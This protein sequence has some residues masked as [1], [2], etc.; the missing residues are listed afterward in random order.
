MLTNGLP[1][2][3]ATFGAAFAD[4]FLAASLLTVGLS[5]GTNSNELSESICLGS[6]LLALFF[7]DLTAALTVADFIS[8]AE[9]LS[10]SITVT[11]LCGRFR[12]AV[13]LDT[14]V[15][16]AL[17]RLLDV[18]AFLVEPLSKSTNEIAADL[19]VFTALLFLAG[20]GLSSVSEFTVN[21]RRLR[22]AVSLALA[23]TCLFDFRFSLSSSSSDEDELICVMRLRVL[24][25]FVVT[26]ADDSGWSSP[27]AVARARLDNTRLAD[28][29]TVDFNSEI[30]LF[31]SVCF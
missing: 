4:N 1:I 26:L 12:S 3:L 2:F 18:V 29:T 17:S 22:P 30:L 8:D 28:M 15:S 19:V 11:A 20:V 9:L 24:V 23:T 16:F 5:S 25:D 14:V 13:D 10:K 6:S 27:A 31:K 7:G 21:G